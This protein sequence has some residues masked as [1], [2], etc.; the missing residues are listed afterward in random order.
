MKTLSFCFLVIIVALT[1]LVVCDIA[2]AADPDFHTFQPVAVQPIAVAS[3]PAN[4][5]CFRTFVVPTAL[6]RDLCFHLFAKS[7]ETAK[8]EL[9][10]VPTVRA[11]YWHADWC[12]TC[13]SLDPLIEQLQ[14]SGYQ[15]HTYDYD[16]HRPR[17][18]RSLPTIVLLRDGEE[19]DRLTG[20]QGEQRTREF[21]RP[22][23]SPDSITQ[24]Q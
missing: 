3:Q 7:H 11:E 6:D 24:N 5:V 14:Q 8:P 15:V 19:I 10:D 18:V 9:A 1:L 20:W 12:R 22:V 2:P 16:R 4:D 13:K 23:A 17:T 21:L